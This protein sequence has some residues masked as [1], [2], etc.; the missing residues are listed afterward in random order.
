LDGFSLDPDALQYQEAP[1]HI[2]KYLDEVNQPTPP[3][4]TKTARLALEKSHDEMK[5]QIKS[6][7]VSKAAG[8]L[9]DLF[10]EQSKISDKLHNTV[11]E[12]YL[13]MKIPY[14]HL[15]DTALQTIEPEETEEKIKEAFPKFPIREGIDGLGITLS[16]STQE[17]GVSAT[18]STYSNLSSKSLDFSQ[19]RQ[20]ERF[21]RFI[22]SGR[23]PHS[24][25]TPKPDFVD[26]LAGIADRKLQ[27]L[28]PTT[29]HLPVAKDA[30][31]SSVEELSSQQAHNGVNSNLEELTEED[32]N[33]LKK[34]RDGS[35]LINPETEIEQLNRIRVMLKGE[36]ARHAAD[37][38][39]EAFF[40]ILSGDGSK[41]EDKVTLAANDC[42]TTSSRNP[43]SM[44]G[45]ETENGIIAA[46][47]PD[48]PKPMSV[49]SSQ[50][51]GPPPNISKSIIRQLSLVTAAIGTGDQKES[52]KIGLDDSIAASP[53]SP[54]RLFSEVASSP[55]TSASKSSIDRAN[56]L[57]SSSP[58]FYAIP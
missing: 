40:K 52:E 37:K 42:T 25:S 31:T 18:S 3:G 23:K 30:S 7:E 41:G 10:V 33:I 26:S 34:V 51:M 58:S 49:S 14:K 5:E 9:H 43:S 20:S 29:S 53:G 2:L 28:S 39:V 12:Q 13:H 22:Q 27:S 35:H 36:R 54:R 19:L 56:S 11:A 21:R 1:G 57:V 48:A 44:V 50:I 16:K 32:C 17:L 8:D 24:A 47:E 38:K 6:W 4:L 55:V 15:R 46:A 45:M